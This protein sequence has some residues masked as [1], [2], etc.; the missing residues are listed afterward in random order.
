[1]NRNNLYC[2]GHAVLNGLIDTLTRH[3]FLQILYWSYTH[4]QSRALLVCLIK[5]A[6]SVFQ[7]TCSTWP[8][9]ICDQAC[10]NKAYMQLLLFHR[11]LLHI[12]SSSH[13]VVYAWLWNFQCLFTTYL[14]SFVIQVAE[15]N[16]N[17][18]IHC[19]DKMHYVTRCISCA[20]TFAGL[21]TYALSA[22]CLVHMTYKMHTTFDHPSQHF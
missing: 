10:K 18:V 14:A 19:W 1:V 21:A 4:E 9:Y 8:M 3:K 5:S 7:D 22:I 15:Y 16:V 17:V 6:L 2:G 11:L 20:H 13:Y 12:T